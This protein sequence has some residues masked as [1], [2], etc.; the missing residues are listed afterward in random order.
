MPEVSKAQIDYATKLSDKFD[1][2]CEENDI[3]SAQLW[4]IQAGEEG[5]SFQRF[6][7]FPTLDEEAF[8][9]A[10]AEE[11]SVTHMIQEMVSDFEKSGNLMEY[12]LQRLAEQ[13]FGVTAQDCYTFLNGKNK[14][15][16]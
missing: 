2:F 9:N 13:K 11:V 4:I 16:Q 14:D 12:N 15:G 1:K 5:T 6:T 3:F 10:S 7:R 8:K